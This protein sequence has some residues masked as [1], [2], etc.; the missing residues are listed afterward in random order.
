MRRLSFVR[1]AAPAAGPPLLVIAA[2]TLFTASPA[3]ALPAYARQT[4]SECAAC[5]VG[6]YGPQLTAYG[7]SFKLAGY[8]STYSWNSTPK[9]DLPISAMAVLNGTRTA[10]DQ[11]S[12]PADGF[13]ANDNLALQEA[14]VFLAGKLAP[15]V[16]AFAQVTY[17]GID[18]KTS[19]DNVDLRYAREFKLG[20]KDAIA[21]VSLNNNPTVQDA[22]NTTP[23]W[24]FPYTSP[25]LAPGRAAPL[26][27]DGLGG[28][29]WG[30]NPY[31]WIYDRYYVELGAYT[32]SSD[33][34]M[35]TF[36][37]DPEA[38]L[39]GAA[40]Y[41]RVAY[42]RS[43]KGQ[44]FSVG[45][46][47][48]SAR[49]R[50][51]PTLPATDRYNDVGIDASY[52]YIGNRKDIYTLDAALIDE[53]RRLDASFA[54]GDANVR[55]GELKSFTLNGTWSH[56]QTWSVTAGLFDTWGNRDTGLYTPAADSGSRAGTP[57]T[58]GY[59]LQLDWTPWGKEDSWA[60]PNVNVRA[61]LQYTGYDKFNGASNNYDGF[62]RD[63]ADNNTLSVFVWTA[64]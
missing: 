61:G 30:L 62:G 63:A 31:L 20:D 41:W 6:G 43:L 36:N 23:A 50:P 26:I 3:Q 14:S 21:G 17:S 45:A 42:S 9:S 2:T 37:I 18:K 15:G 60:A 35:R 7:R 1:R 64:F 27:A 54:A 34:L 44:S 29:V 53:R 49:L 58:R 47:G 5:H 13:N 12:P 51:D 48:M 40:P 28:Q 46:F 25:D 32:R 57:D 4:G 22:W 10:K 59:T 39:D 33:N 19:L 52:Q 24:S 11:S 8:G 38:Y 55:K 16:G 56:D